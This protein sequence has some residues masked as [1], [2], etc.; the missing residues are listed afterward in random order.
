MLLLR[1]IKQREKKALLRE[2]YYNLEEMGLQ[3]WRVEKHYLK[4][5]SRNIQMA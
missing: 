2:I 1:H 3:A 5:S 4:R